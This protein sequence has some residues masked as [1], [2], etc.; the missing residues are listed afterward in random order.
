MPVSEQSSQSVGA[1]SCSDCGLYVERRVESVDDVTHS[2]VQ[3]CAVC[4]N[5]SRHRRV[6][7]GGC[8]G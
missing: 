6:F 4:W 2:T 8:C 3:L 5:A 7:S 1:G